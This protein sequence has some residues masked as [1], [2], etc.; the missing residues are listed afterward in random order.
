MPLPT[1]PTGVTRT[2]L[3]R[4]RALLEAD[5]SITPY[6][7][8]PLRDYPVTT[9]SEADGVV[10]ALWPMDADDAPATMTRQEAERRLML[11]VFVYCGEAATEEQQAEAWRRMVDTTD[12][13]KLAAWKYRAGP[14]TAPRD[15]HKLRWGNDPTTEYRQRTGV[16]VSSNTQLFL[17]VQQRNP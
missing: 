2:Q 16:F 13:L 4:L 10:V 5:A 7:A 11:Q 6:F 14:P 12:L 8:I 15:W 3:D 17:T 1:P 9:V